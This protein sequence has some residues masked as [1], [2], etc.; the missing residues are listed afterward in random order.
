MTKPLKGA[1][2]AGAMLF[3]GAVNA[4]EPTYTGLTGVDQAGTTRTVATTTDSSVQF[5]D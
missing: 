5:P 1:L 4:A 3:A 2:L